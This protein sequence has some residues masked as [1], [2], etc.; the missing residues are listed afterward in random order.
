MPFSICP[1]FDSSRKD[2]ADDGETAIKFIESPEIYPSQKS[3]LMT[4][5]GLP[6][7]TKE[8]IAARAQ[9]KEKMQERLNNGNKDESGQSDKENGQGTRPTEQNRPSDNRQKP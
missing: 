4:Q 6:A 8:E 2:W 3:A 1:S 7:P 9:E 5:M